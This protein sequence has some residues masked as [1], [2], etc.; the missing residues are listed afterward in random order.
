MQNKIKLIEDKL[1]CI[2]KISRILSERRKSNL[3]NYLSYK[4]DKIQLVFEN[5]SNSQNIV[6]NKFL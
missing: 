1:T 3:I 6:A 4:S 5:I 2:H